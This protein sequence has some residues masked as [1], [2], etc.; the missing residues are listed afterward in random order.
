MHVQLSH[1][2]REEV[3]VTKGLAAGL[4]TAYAQAEGVHV[5]EGV[6]VREVQRGRLLLADGSQQSFDECLWCTQAS[7][8]PWLSQTGLQTGDCFLGTCPPN[9]CCK[10]DEAQTAISQSAGQLQMHA[11]QSCQRL[12]MT[13]HT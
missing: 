8:P 7:A 5:R 12:A 6:G 4:N 3:S 9:L 13:S 2:L 11:V 10:P 1:S